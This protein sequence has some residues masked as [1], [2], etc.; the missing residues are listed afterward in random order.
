[1]N[2]LVLSPFRKRI[3]VIIPTSSI[4]MTTF[5]PAIG[6]VSSTGRTSVFVP[7]PLP[8]GTFAC[9][10]STTTAAATTFYPRITFL[11]AADFTFSFSFRTPAAPTCY[12]HSRMIR[13]EV[14]TLRDESSARYPSVLHVQLF[15]SRL[16]LLCSRLA[17]VPSWPRVTANYCRR[18]LGGRQT[19]CA[20]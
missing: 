3:R 18:R 5:S 2:G 20:D 8:I 17:R 14:T 4:G 7:W 19:L 12:S 16:L 9:V 6:V 15:A 10:H 11:T 13:C 1:M